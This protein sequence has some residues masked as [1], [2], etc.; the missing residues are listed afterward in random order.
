MKYIGHI[1]ST[2]HMHVQQLLSSV[3]ETIKLHIVC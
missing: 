1:Y 2:V 3:V